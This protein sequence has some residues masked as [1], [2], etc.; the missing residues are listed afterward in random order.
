VNGP[1]GAEATLSW[2]PDELGVFDPARL[3]ELDEL[4]PPDEAKAAKAELVALFL[5]TAAARIADAEAAHRTGDRR[6][7]VTAAHSLKGMSSMIGATRLQHAAGLIE[8]TAAQ[9]TLDLAEPVTALA[10]EL[11]RLR[12][13][14]SSIGSSL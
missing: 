3:E 9:S 5:T 7:L 4:L 1:V 11:A 10:P 13:A 6:G 12:A 2:I 8:R 14:V